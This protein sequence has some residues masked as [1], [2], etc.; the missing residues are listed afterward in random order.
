M[1]MSRVPWT[2]SLGLSA[3]DAFL[4]RIKRKDKPLLL[5][6]KRRITNWDWRSYFAELLRGDLITDFLVR[7][8]GED[9][10]VK[11]V[12]FVV[13]GAA[14]NN[15]AGGGAIDA[16]KIEELGFGSGVEIEQRVLAICPAIADALGGGARLVGGFVR[17]FAEFSAGVLDGG[18]GALGGFG[19]FVACSFVARALIGVIGVASDGG[20]DERASKPERKT[21]ENT[22]W[23]HTVPLRS[24][25]ELLP[26]MFIMWALCGLR[27]PL[28]CC[29]KKIGPGKLRAPRDRE[30]I[31]D[32]DVKA[33]AR[34][35]PVNQVVVTVDVVNI[36]IIVVTPS[37]RPG[38][39]VDEP[40]AAVVE[41]AIVAA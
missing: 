31:P 34:V 38:V 29:E 18:L 1:S 30:L 12:V 35:L 4:L 28:A 3:M 33:N 23:L 22:E 7:V 2:R 27:L 41:A 25:R 14:G 8:A 24:Y 21:S 9:V 39:I 16:G 17:G 32:D 36:N 20:E 5:I 11:E 15:S 37:R 10:F 19:D 13:I 40:V 6:V 26:C